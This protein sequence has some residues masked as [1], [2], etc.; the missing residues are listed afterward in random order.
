MF[1]RRAAENLSNQLPQTIHGL[2][3]TPTLQLM[4]KL[5]SLTPSF[6]PARLTELTQTPP[7]N[8]HQDTTIRAVLKLRGLS[9]CCL[10]SAWRCAAP[11][12]LCVHKQV[13]QY[14]H[15]NSEPGSPRCDHL[16]ILLPE[17]WRESA[18]R[19]EVKSLQGQMRLARR[20]EGLERRGTSSYLRLFRLRDRGGLA[21]LLQHDEGHL[22]AAFH[23]NRPSSTGESRLRALA[24]S[25]CQSQICPRALLTVRA[26]RP[27]SE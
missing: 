3:A 18:D 26:C 13:T 8:I 17:L 6:G 9:I 4:R 22:S 16:T 1:L 15:I 12:P 24:A 19:A 23:R 11:R 2:S 7:Q 27:S 14:A 25:L 20:S 21:L 5:C 10:F